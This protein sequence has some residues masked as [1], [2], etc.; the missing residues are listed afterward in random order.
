MSLEAVERVV[1]TELKSKERRTAAEQ[2]VK[3]MLADA[4]RNGLA[5]LSKVREDADAEDKA[6]LRQAEEQ[7]QT[8]SDA[9]AQQARHT[10]Q[11][12]CDE[13][14]DRMDAAAELIAGRVVR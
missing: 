6:R 5:L 10:A 7:A 13:A 12:L 3:Q 9:I 1:E 14:A 8:R 11:A 2:Q 4:E